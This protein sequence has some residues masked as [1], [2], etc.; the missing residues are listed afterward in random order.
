METV[1]DRIRKIIS[2]QLNVKVEEVVDSASLADDLGGDSLDHVELMMAIEGEFKGEVSDEEAA[3]LLTV[4]DVI[5]YVEG[6]IL[7]AEGK[8]YSGWTR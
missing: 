4:G 2:F 8:H 6:K 5:K 7:E 1:A 3:K